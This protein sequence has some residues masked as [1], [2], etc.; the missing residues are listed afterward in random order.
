MFTQLLSDFSH[1]S[2]MTAVVWLLQ[3]IAIDLLLSGDNAIIIGMIT[4]HLP[5][6]Q[7]SKVIAIGVGAAVVM[8]LVFASIVVRLLQITGIKIIGGM[9]LLFV[10]YKLY[11]EMRSDQD[12]ALHHHTKHYDGIR[13]AIISIVIADIT[14]SLDNVIA[15]AGAAH[16][17]LA[18]LTIGL[19]VS[20]VAMLFL[21]WWVAQKIDRYPQIQRLGLTIITVI[22]GMMLREGIHQVMGVL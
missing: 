3:V 12:D 8:R 9:M 5:P 10:V 13:S 2:D 22:A 17:N 18:V 16:E 11:K 6:A 4:T 19:I 1:L 15:V 21:S 7:R 14:L 20:I